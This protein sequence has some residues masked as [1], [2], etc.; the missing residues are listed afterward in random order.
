MNKF[1]AKPTEVDGILFASKKEAK[2]YTEL[3][4][5]E[6]AGLITGLQ[7]QPTFKFPDLEYPDRYVADF[8]Y[9]ENG[10]EKVEDVKGLKKSTAYT[11]F[12][13]K[14]ALMRYFHKIEVIEI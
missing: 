6:K 5:M 14:K 10:V 13:I 4:L 12:R 1:N 8:S 9:V 11:V 3:K 2:R 7:L